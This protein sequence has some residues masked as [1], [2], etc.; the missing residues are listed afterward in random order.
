M[1]GKHALTF[2]I[3]KGDEFLREETLD[4]QVIKEGEL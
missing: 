3:Y 4:R 1:A 2:M